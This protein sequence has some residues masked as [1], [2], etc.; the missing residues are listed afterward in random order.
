ME[1]PWGDAG[2]SDVHPAAATGFARSAAA[3]ERGRPGY[4]DGAV[5]RLVAAL[6]G[7]D[8]VD[9]AAGTGK[10][11]RALCARGCSVVA[12]EPVAAMRAAIGP[13]AR[14][15]SGTAEATGL[16]GASADGVTVGQAFHWFDGPRAL[17]EI[18]RVLR[19]GGVLGLIW[20]RRAMQDEINQ[21]IEAILGAHRGRVPAHRSDSWREAL[22]GSPHFGPVREE[23]F[24]SEQTLDADGLADRFGS[25]SFV[26]SMERDERDALLAEVRA[27]AGGGVVTLRYR[28]ELQLATRLG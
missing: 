4:P 22:A 23:A 16:P 3:Y 14:A 10:L 24:A 28:V 6:P 7:R 26:A 1:A 15:V 11:T 27:L 13:P 19:P 18:H 9:L 25:V 5:D 21:R 12:V 17:A 8:V 2:L 20:N